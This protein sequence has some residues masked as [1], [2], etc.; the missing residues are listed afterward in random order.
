MKRKIT[1][2]LIAVFAMMSLTACGKFTCDFCGE[3]KSGKKYKVEWEDEE[4]VLCEDCYEG[5][6]ELQSSL[7][8]LQKLFE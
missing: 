1:V 3:E 6:Q 4:A 2:V 7:E 8:S 5:F